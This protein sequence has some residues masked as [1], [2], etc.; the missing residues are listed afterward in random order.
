MQKKVPLAEKSPFLHY[1]QQN[2]RL[3]IQEQRALLGTFSFF[4]SGHKL[5]LKSRPTPLHFRYFLAASFYSSSAHLNCLSMA[6]NLE[7]KAADA[8]CRFQQSAS[9]VLKNLILF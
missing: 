2:R 6:A 3:F 9:D 8:K 5:S 7:Q 1:M 4:R